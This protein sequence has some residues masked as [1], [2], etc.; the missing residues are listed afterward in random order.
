MS[1]NIDQLIPT[2]SLIDLTKYT[3]DDFNIPDHKITK[4]FDDLILAEY[5]DVSPDGTAIKRGDI[6]IPLNS[7]PKAWRI[8]KVLMV[9]DKCENVQAGDTIVFPSDKGVPVSKLQYSVDKQ[10]QVVAQGV[11][12]NEERL[13]GVCQKVDE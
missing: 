7:A 11:F 5:S 1:A 2:K 9:G 12:L 13:F 3:D 8:A 4:L 6:F 10:T